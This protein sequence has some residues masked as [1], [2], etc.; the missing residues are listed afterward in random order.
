MT[1][2]RKKTTTIK[3]KSLKEPREESDGF[4]ILI[5]R[6]RFPYWLNVKTKR[7]M[8]GGKNWPQVNHYGKTLL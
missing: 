7:W 4:R 1:T 6:S 3:L 2:T 5:A 8:Y